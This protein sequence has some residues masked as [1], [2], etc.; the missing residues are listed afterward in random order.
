VISALSSFFSREI[1]AMLALVGHGRGGEHAAMPTLW[2][3][4]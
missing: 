4:P 2:P 1:F 3:R